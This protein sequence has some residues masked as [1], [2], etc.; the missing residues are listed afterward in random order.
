[1]PFA[2]YE[3]NFE[4]FAGQ[5]AADLDGRYCFDEVSAVPKKI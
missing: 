5:H 1:L 4:T 2:I 3:E